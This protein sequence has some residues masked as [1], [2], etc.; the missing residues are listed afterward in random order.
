M[1][2]LF[3]SSDVTDNKNSVIPWESTRDYGVGEFLPMAG[4]IIPLMGDQYRIKSISYVVHNGPIEEH[5]PIFLVDLIAEEKIIKVSKVL[6][7]IDTPQ[8]MA[9]ILRTYEKVE[10]TFKKKDGS[11]RVMQATLHKSVIEPLFKDKPAED[12]EKI[13]AGAAAK[14]EQ[15][16]VTVYDVAAQDWR[17]FKF[18]S[19]ISVEFP[20]QEGNIIHTANFTK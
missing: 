8:K 2:V 10:V 7:E 9:E 15:G 5:D 16:L 18:D 17:S 6:V 13:Q 11:V 19:I 1:R 12:V 20:D 3:K 14:L 4:D